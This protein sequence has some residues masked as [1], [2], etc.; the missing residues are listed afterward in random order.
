MTV[1]TAKWTLEDFHQMVDAG[2]LEGRAVEFLNGEIVEMSPEGAPHAAASS[3]AGDYL[4]GLLGGRAQVRQSKPITI[5]ALVSEPEPDLAIVRRLG[6]GYRQQHPTPED[7]F[8]LVEYAQTSLSK[9]LDEKKRLYAG[10]GAGIPEYWVVNLRDRSLLVFR[11]PAD[12]VYRFEQ[13]LGQGELAPLAF[14]EVV[15]SVDRLL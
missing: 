5:P 1:T 10:A 2:L 9:D 3:D 14:P 13:T 4:S 7:V 15:I 6:R 8:W 11:Q 12:G